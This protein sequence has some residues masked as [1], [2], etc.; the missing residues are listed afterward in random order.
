MTFSKRVSHLCF[1]IARTVVMPRLHLSSWSFV[2]FVALALAW[3]FA[4]LPPVA[5]ALVVTGASKAHSFSHQARLKADVAEL[6]T[7][8]SKSSL[9]AEAKAVAKTTAAQ[10]G[11]I[12]KSTES[13]AKK[14]DLQVESAV[15]QVAALPQTKVF[16]RTEEYQAGELRDEPLAEPPRAVV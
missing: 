5:S 15:S 2:P 13:T 10:T 14:I 16:V 1:R 3:L 6:L 11:P 8:K 12:G 9:W 4:S 7:G